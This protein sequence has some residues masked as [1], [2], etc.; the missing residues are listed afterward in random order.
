[1]RALVL[2]ST[3]SMCVFIAIAASERA[4]AQQ[5]TNS[6]TCAQ[7][8]S[9]YQKQGRVYTRTRNGTVLPIYGGVPEAQGRN[10]LC[11]RDRSQRPVRV[12][13]RDNRRCTIAYKC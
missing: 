13:T 9:L 4:A 6:M 11:G 12:I 10:L 3:V 5:L 8:K 2:T 7:A 1:M